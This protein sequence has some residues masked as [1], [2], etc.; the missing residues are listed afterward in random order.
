MGEPHPTNVAVA[1]HDAAAYLMAEP[2]W[3]VNAAAIATHVLRGLGEK[4]WPV[5]CTVL[6]MNVP[7]V[8]RVEA[9]ESEE[10][11]P[12]WRDAVPG[13]P[14]CV[15]ARAMPREQSRLDPE[16]ID[17]ARRRGRE[18][19]AGH[20][21][22]WVPAW[23]SYIDPSA[24]Q[25]AKPVHG[26]ELGPTAWQGAYE[27]PAESFWERPD[28]GLSIIRPTALRGFTTTPAWARR[29]DDHTRQLAREALNALRA[30]PPSGGNTSGVPRGY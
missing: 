17:A 10:S 25:F 27:P 2:S 24:G 7:Y 4:S 22:T 9:G 30:N 11:F 18:G 28:G 23:T 8:E 1:I 14:Y 20:V 12:A 13:D 19:L 5:Q 21:V 16:Q 3:C 6:H 29:G 26:I 15:W